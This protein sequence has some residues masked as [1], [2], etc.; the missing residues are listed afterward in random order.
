K[1]FE[2]VGYQDRLFEWDHPR[3][4]E[5]IHDQWVERP[6]GVHC[7][8]TKIWPFCVTG[9]G[10]G[11]Q[12]YD[13]LHQKDTHWLFR[14]WV[15]Y[16][17]KHYMGLDRH[18][19]IKWFTLFYDPLEK[20]NA[21]LRD[22]ISAYASLALAPYVLPQDKE[23]GTLLYESSVR[24]LGWDDPKK[25]LLQLHPDPRFALIALLAAREV[26]DHQTEDRLRLLAE[27]EFEPRFFGPD[28]DRFGW[29]FN[30][31]EEWPRGQLA[32]LM[33]LSE[34]GEPGSWSRVFN[35]PNLDKFDQPTLQGVD[36]PNLGVS[37]AWNDL[38]HGVLWVET[39]AATRSARG[40][41]TAWR[42]TKLADPTSVSVTCDGQPFTAWRATGPEGIEVDSDVD[43]HLFRI[44]TGCRGGPAAT[45]GAS[46]EVSGGVSTKG[47][48][49]Y[50]PSLGGGGSCCG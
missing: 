10:L 31:G 27:H 14:R 16:A 39:Y 38:E 15:E 3:L 4:V 23:F 49:L 7:E 9:V 44:V 20:A 34:L 32:S 33:V 12:L 8:N 29:W 35:Q 40:T 26:G 46:R 48:T 50:V 13:R 25:P 21:V 47:R 6:A 28:E 19:A 5:F 42:V 1:P 22:D 41:K 43:D 24:T 17:R 36:F 2:V 30:F 45:E 37:Q 11:L 18:G